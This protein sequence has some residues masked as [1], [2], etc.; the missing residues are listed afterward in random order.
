MERVGPYAYR[1]NTP[2]G[3]HPVFYIDKLRLAATDPF[4]S[5]R[6]DDYQP[7]P[8]LIEGEPEWE[9]EEIQDTR[10]KRWGRGF[11]REFLVKWKGYRVP[12]WTA[13]HLLQDTAAL[14]VWEARNAATGEGG[15]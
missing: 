15:G 7:P 9:I 2:A 4:P 12:E 3:I 6:N 5:Q 11:R 14:D 13:A 10:A 1:L 8:I